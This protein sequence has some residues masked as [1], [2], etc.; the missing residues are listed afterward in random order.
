MLKYRKGSLFCSTALLLSA[1]SFTAIADDSLGQYL[2]E[3]TSGYV[4]TD[5]EHSRML[6]DRQE[7]VTNK[8]SNHLKA[9]RDGVIER[10]SFYLGGR[11]IASYMR[12]HTNTAGKYPILSRIPN[13]HTTGR[14]GNEWV[15]N[16]GSINTSLNYDILTAF[17][18]GEYTEVEYPG[19]DQWQLRKYAFVIGDLEQFPVY[20]AFGRNTVAFGDFST[21]APYTHS[22]NSHYF[23]TQTD[24]PHFELGYVG[25]NF[26]ATFSLLP[27]D[28]GLRVAHA[29]DKNGYENFAANVSG[30]IAIDSKR[31]LKIGGGFLRGSIYDSAIAHHPPGVGGDDK[32]WNPI[33]DVN[34]TLSGV[35]YDIMAEYTRTIDDWPATNREVSALT[36]QGR[37]RDSLLSYPT[38]Y[39]FVFSRGEHGAKDTEWEHMIQTVAGVEARLLPN[40]EVGAEYVFNAGFVPL[41]MPQVTGDRGVRSH[42][43]IVGTKVTF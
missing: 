43:V 3:A 14:N 20:L 40:V 16:D 38:T 4:K 30:V 35:N 32:D 7:N 39:S 24:D 18:Q 17:V 10:E 26:D 27:N 9:K 29:P 42:T 22:H 12:E 21:Y 8:I 6:F 5:L 15:I 19:Q 33:W 41:I 34:L 37:Y 31:Q 13:L 11:F 23:W 1:L 36:L 28:R 25:E 2:T